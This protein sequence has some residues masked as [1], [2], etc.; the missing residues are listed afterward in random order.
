MTAALASRSDVRAFFG[1]L[2]LPATAAV[3][4]AVA[5]LSDPRGPRVG[6]RLQP[7]LQAGHPAL[8][9]DVFL[10]ASSCDA[11]AKPLP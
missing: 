1:A 8:F 4:L 11:G 10:T 3:L 2:A 6:L 5:W 7:L 9:S